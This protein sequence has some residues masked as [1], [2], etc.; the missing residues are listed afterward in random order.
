MGHVILC[1]FNKIFKGQGK[2]SLFG[3]ETILVMWDLKLSCYNKNV[4]MLWFVV[5]N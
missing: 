4:Q 2:S 1:R 5:K 3:T